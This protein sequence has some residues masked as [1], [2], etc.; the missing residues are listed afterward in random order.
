MS[1]QIK[2]NTKEKLRIIDT[3]LPSK[4]YF[5]AY[6]IP[7]MRDKDDIILELLDVILDNK[8]SQF[9]IDNNF[10]IDS[11]TWKNERL[12]DGFFIFI[13]ATN[14]YVPI[15]KSRQ[16][17][18]QFINKLKREGIDEEDINIGKKT[19]L[20]SRMYE[21]YWTGK[22]AD[23][24]SYSEILHGDYK[25]YTNQLELIKGIDNED[26]KRVA[27]KYFINEKEIE[28]QP[29]NKNIIKQLVYSLY[30]TFF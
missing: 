21:K 27:N 14:P 19:F 11:Q 5:R 1:R 30:Y 13:V 29:E 4:L 16:A 12:G 9:K 28:M 2:V 20:R 3:K 22:I 8:F 26:F 6:S 10:V 17:I 25:M 18:S 7:T 15:K 23:K 24:L